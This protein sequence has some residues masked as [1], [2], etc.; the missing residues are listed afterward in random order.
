MTIDYQ[1][2]GWYKCKITNNV[3]YIKRMMIFLS[4]LLFVH[5]GRLID[6]KYEN[7]DD[8]NGIKELRAGISTCIM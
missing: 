7:F 2:L 5:Y 3:F 6:L 8:W 4:D 1:H